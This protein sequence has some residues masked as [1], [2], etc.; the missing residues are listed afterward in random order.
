MEY[1][2]I[3]IAVLFRNEVLIAEAVLYLLEEL[4]IPAYTRKNTM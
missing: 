4:R 1:N 2:L 3:A